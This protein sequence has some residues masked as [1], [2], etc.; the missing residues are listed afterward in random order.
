MART[1]DIKPQ[2]F[3]N[4]E[5]AECDPLARLLFIGL[6]TLADCQGR[7]ECRP[8]R[9]KAELFPYD[10]CDITAMLGQLQARGFIEIYEANGVKVLEIPKFCEHQRCHPKEAP[11]DLPAR[12]DR[13][14]VDF[15]GKPCLGDDEPG[16]KTA[17]CAL[18]SFNPLILPS[19][20]PPSAP[21]KPLTRT[22]SKPADPI[23]WDAVAG[24]QGITDADHAEWSRAY[25]A[26]DIPVEIAKAHQ[27]LKVNPKKA[28]KSNWRKFLVGW[29][30]RC[31][32]KG[33]TNRGT[34]ANRPEEIRHPRRYYRADA[35]KAMTANEYDA[36]RSSSRN[37]LGIAELAAA[38]SA[39]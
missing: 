16:K 28:Q 33:G 3:K 15:H 39:S 11:S 27:W 29:L 22:R 37:G 2:F 7:L 32:D 4:D 6:W 24:W 19:S 17:S 34:P 14:A 35:G 36:W 30:T 31:Q 12:E 5:L 23:R 1:R 13:Q 10:S 20:N 21:T 18:P 8:L 38:K 9:I 25:P 26:A